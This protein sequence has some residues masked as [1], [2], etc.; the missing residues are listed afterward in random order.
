MGLLE[1]LGKQVG[2]RSQM[3]WRCPHQPAHPRSLARPTQPESFGKK[4]NYKFSKVLGDG[5][6]GSVKQAVWH[7]PD[8]KGDIGVAIKCIK[9]KSVTLISNAVRCCKNGGADLG[10]SDRTLKGNEKIVYEE[11]DVLHGLN[12]P[13]VGE[14]TASQPMTQVKLKENSAWAQSSSTNGS[15][16]E[17]SST[18]SSS[19]Y[20]R[21]GLPSSSPSNLTLWS[22]PRLASGGELFDR[23]CDQ[24]RFTEHDAVAVVRSTLH[25]VAYLHKHNIVHRD[26]KPE[27]LLYRSKEAD[28]L[29]RFTL[30][31]RLQCR[32]LTN[33]ERQV[34]ADFGIAKHLEEEDE[35]LTTVCGSPGYAGTPRWLS[36]SF[37][38]VVC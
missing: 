20:H 21:S 5:S 27:N 29:V 33:S 32:K 9:K 7:R 16:L 10:Q 1:G 28:D 13:N 14:L 26:L 31:S 38:A 11:M 8:G 17:T 18:W 25:G 35:V 19:A 24:G 34:I 4:K 12:H 23:I 15:N 2:P 30:H 37:S 36:V 6:F 3:R 22:D